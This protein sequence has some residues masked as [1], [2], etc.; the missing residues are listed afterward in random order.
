MTGLPPSPSIPFSA[1][2]CFLILRLFLAQPPLVSSPQL[3]PFIFICSPIFL[4]FLILGPFS[5]PISVPFA[6]LQGQVKQKKC[7]NNQPAVRESPLPPPL[8]M[9]YYGI[10]RTLYNHY[11]F[12]CPM[13]NLMRKVAF[14]GFMGWC[15]GRLFSI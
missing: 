8:P 13:L 15:T 3:Y 14:H 5:Q 9:I 11:L 12:C 6:R 10:S 4:S 1:S 7:G 2:S